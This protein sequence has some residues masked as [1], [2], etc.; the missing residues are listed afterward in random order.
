M[1]HVH[2]LLPWLAYFGGEEV[3]SLETIVES[4]QVTYDDVGNTH[5]TLDEETGYG[6]S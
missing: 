4:F 2:Q 3:S 5:Q 6:T 1:A